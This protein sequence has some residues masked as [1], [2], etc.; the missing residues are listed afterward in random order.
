MNGNIV[1]LP[2]QTLECPKCGSREVKTAFEM[3]QLPYGTG[4]DAVHLA[5]EIPVRR[6]CACGFEFTDA[7]ADDAR[8]AAIRGHLQLLSPKE[9]REIRADCSASRKEFAAV[10]R[11]GEASLARWE[12]GHLL[13]SGALDH[14]LFL[15]SF[16]ENYERLLARQETSHSG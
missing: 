12:N 2:V 16:S 9:I 3:E 8:D 6:C 5:V 13:Q 10:T 11:I 1:K 15:L 14:F 7:A 4:R